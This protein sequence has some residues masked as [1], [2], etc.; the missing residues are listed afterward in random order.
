MLAWIITK[1]RG[2]LVCDKYDI[3]LV[4]PSYGTIREDIFVKNREVPLKQ[5]FTMVHVFIEP[6]V[7]LWNEVFC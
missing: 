4:P 5:Q 7:A 6:I 2:Q 3:W 1:G